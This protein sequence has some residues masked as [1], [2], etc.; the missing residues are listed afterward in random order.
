MKITRVV[1]AASLAAAFIAPT[2]GRAASPSDVPSCMSATVRA[3]T[4]PGGFDPLS[5]TADQLRCYGFPARPTDAPG[6]QAW[7]S[8]MQ[9]AK[10]YV[11]PAFTAAPRHSNLPHGLPRSLPHGV[12][13]SVSSSNYSGYSALQSNNSSLSKFVETSA[14]WNVPRAYSTPAGQWASPWVGMGGTSNGSCCILQA[15]Q[16]STP[17]ST[18]TYKFWYEDYPDNTVYY[19]S[20]PSISPG[21][22]V[23]VDVTDNQ[24]GTA[25]FFWENLASGQYT[26]YTPNV[27]HY[28]DSSADWIVEYSGQSWN[29]GTVGFTAVHTNAIQNGVNAG[30]NLSQVNETKYYVPGGA[31]PGAPGN[32][33]T[34]FN[35]TASGSC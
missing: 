12:S 11:V 8:A 9:L 14:Q 15:G 31:C 17:G 33:G 5:A 23:Y 29:F 24:N 21:N 27:S 30:F 26:S 20:A 22:Q 7:T 10:E 2:M 19:A 25:T 13:G 18:P 1:L 4:P 32:G 6:L 35:D 16:D 3:V 28:D 34:S